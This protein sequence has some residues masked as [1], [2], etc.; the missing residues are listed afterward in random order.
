MDLAPSPTFMLWQFS[1]LFLRHVHK[2]EVVPRCVTAP[3]E[4]SAKDHN[5]LVTSTTM[6]LFQMGSNVI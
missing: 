5:I 2:A 6:R 1:T 4:Q 3:Y